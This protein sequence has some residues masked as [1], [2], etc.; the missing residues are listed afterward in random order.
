MHGKG[1]Y[2]FLNGEIYNGEFKNDL[3]HG[4]GIYKWPDGK[5][6]K[7]HWKNNNFIKK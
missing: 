3:F 7:G 5:T 6:E 4:N 1:V 2:T